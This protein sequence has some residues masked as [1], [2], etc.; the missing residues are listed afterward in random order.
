MMVVPLTMWSQPQSLAFSQAAGGPSPTPQT[1]SILSSGPPVSFT[2]ATDAAWLSASPTSGTT[3]AQISV[4][5]NGAGLAPGSY[6]G[7]VIA[8]GPNATPLAVPVTLT[9]DPE[10][11][12]TLTP[13]EFNFFYWPGIA[14]FDQV[15][16]ADMNIT[17][18]KQAKWAA[19]KSP[20]NWFYFSN[21]VT[22][23]TT[24]YRLV[25][26]VAWHSLNTSGPVPTGT[27][28]GTITVSSPDAT[29]SPQVATLHGYS[30]PAA[31]LNLQQ[32]VSLQS[33]GTDPAPRTISVSADSPTA[34]T[35]SVPSGNKWLAVSPSSGTTP[36][37]LT[38]SV[39][40][41]G[42]QSGSY[43]ETV[44]MYAQQPDGPPAPMRINVTLFFA[45]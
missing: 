24:P 20:D 33:Q 13:K 17:S 44:T 7:N 30:L 41:A 32:T 4:S 36:A 6:H 18:G 1:L 15:N 38:F 40:T 39:N 12:L 27:F 25:I 34:F 37:S 21:Y 43:G 11:Y 45:R 2:I 16:S 3:S 26:G 5:I 8:S 29:N 42:L 31:P 19:V 35:V 14:T 28:T 22:N 23:G 9:V 10:N